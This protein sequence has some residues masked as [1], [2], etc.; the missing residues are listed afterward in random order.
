MNQ[1]RMPAQKPYRSRQDYATPRTFLDAVESRFGK[2]G[3]DLACSKTN[4]VV[5][6]SGFTEADDSL[7]QDWNSLI[8]HLWLNPPFGNIAP[9]ARKCAQFRGDGAIFL[10]VPAS[11]GSNWFRDHVFGKSRV[12]FLNP[13]LSFDGKAPFPKDLMLCIFGLGYDGVALWGWR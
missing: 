12:L 11:V 10:L 4:C 6:G 5:P 13:R 1:S 7:A 9:W 3:W 2:L 8:G